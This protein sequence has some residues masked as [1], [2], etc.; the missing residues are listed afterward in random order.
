MKALRSLGCH[1]VMLTG[2]PR[3]HAGRYA[4]VAGIEEVKSNL[5]TADKLKAVADLAG[6]YGFAAMAGEGINDAPRSGPGGHGFAMGAAGTHIATKPG[7]C[8]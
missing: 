8:A 2:D 3:S 4:A 1:S 6:P 7:G 5:P